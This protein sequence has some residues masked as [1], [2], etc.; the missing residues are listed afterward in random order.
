MQSES[1]KRVVGLAKALVATGDRQFNG[2]ES[3]N[4]A[5]TIMA[6]LTRDFRKS[7][8][9]AMAIIQ[10]IV[11]TGFDIRRVRG[12]AYAE[13]SVQFGGKMARLDAAQVEAIRAIST[14]LF[15][16]SSNAA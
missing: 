5:S 16:Q 4:L 2:D 3:R 10:H 8:M 12:T 7:P 11:D 9:F 13:F 1:I 6:G 15:S 14:N